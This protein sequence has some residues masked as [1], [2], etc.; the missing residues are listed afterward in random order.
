MLENCRLMFTKPDANA[1]KSR[2]MF[3]VDMQSCLHQVVQIKQ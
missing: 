3:E 1:R 2:E